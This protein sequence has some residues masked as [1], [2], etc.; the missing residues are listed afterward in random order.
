MIHFYKR[1]I[2]KKMHYDYVLTVE[3]LYLLPQYF[4]WRPKILGWNIQNSKEYDL[5]EEF[6]LNKILVV[7]SWNLA[8]LLNPL[9][10]G[11]CYNHKG[12]ER[13]LNL[14]WRLRGWKFVRLCIFILCYLFGFWHR[15]FC[16]YH[17]K[18]HTHECFILS[19]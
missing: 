17:F 11:L 12:L 5:K 4:W 6:F 8:A 16:P 3:N 13:I 7:R 1:H 15:L 14:P 10:E 2:S 9:F 18:S 19:K